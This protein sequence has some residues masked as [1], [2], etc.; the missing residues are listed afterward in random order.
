[1]RRTNMAKKQPK[2]WVYSPPKPPKPSVPEKV[3]T[4]VEAKAK[5]LIDEVLRPEHVKGPEDPRWNY[6]TDIT[7]KWHRS[8]FYFVGV[9]ASPGPNAISPS[10]EAGFARMEYVG[11]GRFNLSYMRHTDK[12]W[13]VEEGLTAH[14]CLE[15]IR[16]GGI[17]Q[18]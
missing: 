17:F 5:E 9:W 14:K 4:E 1:M 11:D 2:R 8:Y 6:L 13:Q 3:K 15:R 18:P 16:D 7:C 10:F 12:W